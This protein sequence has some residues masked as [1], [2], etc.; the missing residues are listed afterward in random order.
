[1]NA[2]PRSLKAL[3]VVGLLAGAMAGCDDGGGTGGAGG[4]TNAS[5][6]SKMATATTGTKMSSSSSSMGPLCGN[7]LFDDRP[8]CEACVEDAC[9]SELLDCDPAGTT[10]CGKLVVCL[11]NCPAGD[12][13]CQDACVAADETAGGGGL[14][15]LQGLFSCYDANCEQTPECSYPICDSGFIFPDLGCAECQTDNCCTTIK[16]CSANMACN[17]CLQDKTGPDVCGMAGS[18]E[19]M[20]FQAQKNC[21]EV[22]CKLDCTFSICGSNLGYNA[23][24]CNSCLTDNCCTPFNACFADTTCNGCL[25]APT[26]AGCM[27]NQLFTAFTSCRDTA[28]AMTCGD[29]GECN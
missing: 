9:C 12:G 24:S 28:G 15:S 16:D 11:N 23:T 8:D 21:F 13:A 18:T 5:S 29:A 22:T 3:F 20:L 6:G 26:G 19:D 25:T 7:L 1:M 4:A 27:T 10:D 17:A 14:T 2:V